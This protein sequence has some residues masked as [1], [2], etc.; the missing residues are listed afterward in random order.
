MSYMPGPEPEQEGPFAQFEEEAIVSLA[1]DAPDYFLSVSHLVKP[2]LFTSPHVGYVMTYL[3]KHVD[4]YM[5]VPTRHLVWNQIRKHITTSDVYYEDVERVVKRPAS[6]RDLPAVKDVLSQ[7]AKKQAFGLLYS[8]DA[9]LA[10]AQGDY[11]S[12]E[13]IVN[14][15]NKIGDN[16]GSLFW[17]YEQFEELFEP[18]SSDHL[19]TG[20]PKLDKCLNN[21][22]P[23]RK[24][25][26]CWMA[27][28]G[29]GKCHTLQTK[30]YEESLSRIY[31]LEL[32]DGT[33]KR[34]AGYRAVQTV[35]G[36]V[37]VCD[38]VE[39]DDIVSLPVDDDLPDLRLPVV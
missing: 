11:D 37:R 25:V 32:E 13:K 8:E 31:E 14:D 24:E 3:M 23:S 18:D 1:F 22:G 2:D 9:Q 10:Y 38:L 26:V 27:P 30:I 12:L 15:A 33:I 34:L 6:P 4:D 7:W 19:S 20:F 16:T 39:A 28:T 29:V 5:T 17:F 35:R 36:E 21:G